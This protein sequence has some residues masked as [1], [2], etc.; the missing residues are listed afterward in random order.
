APPCTEFTRAGAQHWKT[1]HPRRLEL[2]I[3]TVKTCLTIIEHYRPT[4]WALEN[5]VGRIARCVPELGKVVFSFH[6]NE[7]GHP[8][9]KRTILW[10]RFTPTKKRKPI[11]VDNRQSPF[12]MPPSSN[13]AAL[14][15]I[16]PSGFAN[17][18]FKAN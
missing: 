3:R 11:K 1:K 15:S 18:F 14:R 7:F 6:P 12:W 9:T 4:W 8:W 16:T 17:A 13:R 10:G 5:P 2:A